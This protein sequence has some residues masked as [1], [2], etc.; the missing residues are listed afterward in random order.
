LTKAL[1]KYDWTSSR[2]FNQDIRAAQQYI[3][4]VFGQLGIDNSLVMIGPFRSKPGLDP[5]L[6]EHLGL[7]WTSERTFGVVPAAL[8]GKPRVDKRG[9]LVHEMIHCSGQNTIE[10]DG[11]GNVVFASSGWMQYRDIDETPFYGFSLFEEVSS[12]ILEY[13]YHRSLGEDECEV[14]YEIETPLNL[15]SPLDIAIFR[16]ATEINHPE[17]FFA[18][19]KEALDSNWFKVLKKYGVK[20]AS[21]Q[22]TFSQF[23][24]PNMTEEDWENN[25]Q[26]VSSYSEVLASME[27]FADELFSHMP[28]N[29]RVETFRTELLRA[30]CPGERDAFL[31]LVEEKV[32]SEGVDFFAVL[33]PAHDKKDPKRKMRHIAML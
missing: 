18:L 4:T 6:P 17:L 33:E 29:M 20:N 11:A 27:R 26:F 31:G 28:K 2:R 16:I 10:V 12:A 15:K 7:A 23:A 9:V 5:D 25:K 13:G 22:T 30:K 21:V 1:N 14:I 19:H 8:R 3:E 24:R 32:G